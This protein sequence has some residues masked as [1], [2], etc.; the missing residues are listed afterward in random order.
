MLKKSKLSNNFEAKEKELK[1]ILKK[2]LQIETEKN[3][4]SSVNGKLAAA[5]EKFFD[6][7]ENAIDAYKNLT[8]QISNIDKKC[9]ININNDHSTHDSHDDNSVHQKTICQIF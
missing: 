3:L 7:N 5:I 1:E 6:Y 9:E 4:I 8:E 2:N